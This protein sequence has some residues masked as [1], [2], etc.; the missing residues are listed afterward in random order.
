[1]ILDENNNVSSSA[2]KASANNII[3]SVN[4]PEAS[5]LT[6]QI[7]QSPAVLRND[8]EEMKKVLEKQAEINLLLK[9]FIESIICIIVFYQLLQNTIYCMDIFDLFICTI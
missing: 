1:M 4:N 6:N 7:L 8:E 3:L 5:N 9:Y 2:P